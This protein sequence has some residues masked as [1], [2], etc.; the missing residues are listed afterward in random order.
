VTNKER[1]HCRSTQMTNIL[2]YDALLY[3]YIFFFLC[4]ERKTNSILNRTQQNKQTNKQTETN[5]INQSSILV[6]IGKPVF[7]NLTNL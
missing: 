4:R 1:V 2:R 6:N 5:Q 7:S 3:V